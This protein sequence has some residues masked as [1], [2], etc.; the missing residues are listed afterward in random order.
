[1]KAGSKPSSQPKAVGLEKNYHPSK[2]FFDWAEDQFR[3]GGWIPVFLEKTLH[4][5][6]FRKNAT[7]CPAEAGN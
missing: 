3:T 4:Q 1:L 7:E 5:L 6:Q 2:I